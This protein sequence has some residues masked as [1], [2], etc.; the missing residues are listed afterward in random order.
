MGSTTHPYGSHTNRFSVQLQDPPDLSSSPATHTV[1]SHTL[2][3][4][5]RIHLFLHSEDR[6]RSWPEHTFNRLQPNFTKTYLRSLMAQGFKNTFKRKFKNLPTFLTQRS[7][8][9]S[10]DQ[11]LQRLLTLT[12]HTQKIYWFLTTF[13]LQQEQQERLRN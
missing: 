10:K 8:S 11:P 6:P 12:S 9:Q 5:P 3:T 2:K 13:S 1:N 4:S 7:G